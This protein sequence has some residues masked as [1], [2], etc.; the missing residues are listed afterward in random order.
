MNVLGL[1]LRRGAAMF[2]ASILHLVLLHRDASDRGR[3]WKRV[4]NSRRRTPLAPREKATRSYRG[5]LLLLRTPRPTGS[6]QR[7]F[8]FWYRIGIR[9]FI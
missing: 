7:S 1:L 6:P 9:R 3:I 5:P 8:L 4:S 2:I